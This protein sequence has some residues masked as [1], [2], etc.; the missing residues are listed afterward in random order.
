[1]Y[2]LH[3]VA[4]H[5]SAFAY[6]SC[7]LWCKEMGKERLQ[8]WHAFQLWNVD[9]IS[10]FNIVVSNNCI[11]DTTGNS[12]WSAGLIFGYRIWVELNQESQESVRVQAQ[13]R[14]I[15]P[16][17]GSAYVTMTSRMEYHVL[18]WTGSPLEDHP[19]V[20]NVSKSHQLDYWCTGWATV[21]TSTWI[22]PRIISRTLRQTTLD[23]SSAGHAQPP[24]LYD[25]PHQPSVYTT[26]YLST[27]MHLTHG[28]TV[29]G[30]IASAGLM[31]AHH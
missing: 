16:R 28:Q 17:Y 13:I 12:T 1:M 5:Y 6:R 23:A 27:C 14:L 2:T 18:W 20:S 4:T 7:S 10:K 26:T 29:S 21:M 25:R 24:G 30:P 19:S 11:T 8:C 15:G 31:A 22:P 3:H 9:V